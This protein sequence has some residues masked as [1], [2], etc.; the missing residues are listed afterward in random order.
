MTTD[1]KITRHIVH[2]AQEGTMTM[3]YNEMLFD[4]LKE[5]RSYADSLGTF[6]WVMM[7]LLRSSNI[8]AGSVQLTDDMLML[9]SAL[10]D[11]AEGVDTFYLNQK[12]EEAA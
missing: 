11:Y 7:L 3:P 1:Q 6:G 9:Q 8:D 12:E 2:N 10:A 5:P 4:V